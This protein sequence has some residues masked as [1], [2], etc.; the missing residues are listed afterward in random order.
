MPC[1]CPAPSESADPRTEGEC[2][3]CGRPIDSELINPDRQLAA[4][5]DHLEAAARGA[6]KKAPP[7]FVAFREHCEMRERIG[8]E[9]FGVGYLAKD[10]A[11][12]ALEEC[13]DTAIYMALDAIRYS[14]QHGEDAD[15]SLALTAA[16]HAYRSYEAVRRLAAKRR[17]SP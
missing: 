10:N 7:I 3:K 6:G 9:R 2:A 11:A 1:Q 15:L 12:E 8:R 5:F 16:F 13:C 14:R 17:G 4:F